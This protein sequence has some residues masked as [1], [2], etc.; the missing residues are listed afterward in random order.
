MGK[1]GDPGNSTQPLSQSQVLDVSAQARPV[2]KHDQ[3]LWKGIVVSPDEFAPGRGKRARARSWAIGGVLVAGA[4]G[5]GL[6][7][8]SQRS[9]GDAPATPHAEMAAP[10]PTPDPP[11]APS[12]TA[13]S[14]TLADA[15]LAGAPAD[16]A[17]APVADAVSSVAP[18]VVKSAATTT[19]IK[20]KKTGSGKKRK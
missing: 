9:G 3:S 19:T 16:A 11:R 15:A 12:T 14:T 5:G 13:A 8:Y 4:A 6:Y 10:A 1:P 18:P 7:A 20:R 17:A 2:A